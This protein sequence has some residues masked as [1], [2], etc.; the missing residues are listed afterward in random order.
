VMLMRETFISNVPAR[1]HMHP[2]LEE[3]SV[4]R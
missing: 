2:A 3:Q 4:S 1:Q